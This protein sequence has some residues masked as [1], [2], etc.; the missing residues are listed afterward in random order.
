MSVM[1]MS[2]RLFRWKALF[3]GDVVEIARS[4]MVEIDDGGG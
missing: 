4:L 1:A 2:S 3:M